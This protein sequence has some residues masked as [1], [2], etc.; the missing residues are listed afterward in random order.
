MTIDERR[1]WKNIDSKNK[2][3]IFHCCLVCFINFYS[4]CD[5]IT[6]VLGDNLSC[7]CYKILQSTD[8]KST[9]DKVLYS[10]EISTLLLLYFYSIL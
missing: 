7:H 10:K 2:K 8:R 6:Y 1:Y 3:T 4:F 9:N 5:H